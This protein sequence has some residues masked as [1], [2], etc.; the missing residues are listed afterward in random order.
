[1]AD[2]FFCHQ[3]RRPVTLRNTDLICSSCGGDFVEEMPPALQQNAAETPQNRLPNSNS[4][5]LLNRPQ[6]PVGVPMA[7]VRNWVA[8]LFAA[9]PESA[10]NAARPS[11]ARGVNRDE[12]SVMDL[13]QSIINSA[14]TGNVQLHFD[15]STD[16]NFQGQGFQINF[17]ELFGDGTRPNLEQL[18]A[19]VFEEGGRTPSHGISEEVLNQYLPM[20]KV[21]QK[22]VDDGVQCTTCFDTFKLDEPVACLDCNHIFHRPCIDPWLKQKS[23][24]PVCRQPVDVI[25]WRNRPRVPNMSVLDDLD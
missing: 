14:S 2:T 13:F 5:T 19:H 11:Q 16:P 4:P 25:A 12:P 9:M 20:T 24:C 8:N 23:S 3:C 7:G 15:F 22:H 18:F 6:N 17:G 1:M 10:Q 21:T